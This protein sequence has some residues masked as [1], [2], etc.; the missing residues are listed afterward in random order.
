MRKI[1]LTPWTIELRLCQIVSLPP[2]GLKANRKVKSY[3]SIVFKAW[4]IQ[5][6]RGLDNFNS[7][8]VQKKLVKFQSE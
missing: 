3:I 8:F 6:N 2:K 4:S 7:R 1:I 5:H